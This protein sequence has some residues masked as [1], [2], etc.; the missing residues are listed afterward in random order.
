MIIIV[1]IRFVVIIQMR[2]FSLKKN[3]FVYFQWYF[4][5]AVEASGITWL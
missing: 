4:V 1:S 5:V 3:I 2:R